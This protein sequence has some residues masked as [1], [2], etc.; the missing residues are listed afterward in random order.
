MHTVKLFFFGAILAIIPVIA[1]AQNSTNSPYTRNGYGNIADNAF[2]SQRGMGGIGLGL[3]NPQM[4]NPMN[5]AS[6]SSVDSMTFMFDMGVNGQ[7]SWFKD[8]FGQEQKK[9][10]TWSIL[11]SNS[12]LLK[13]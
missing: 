8:S 5:P 6:F 9:M 3:R 1:L 2:I 13:N 12:R 11:L 7:I 4:I 10:Q